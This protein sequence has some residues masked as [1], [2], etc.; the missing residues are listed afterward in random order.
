MCLILLH[1]VYSNSPVSQL[2][3]L[4][5]DTSFNSYN[6]RLLC[7]VLQQ[8]VHCVFFPLF[9]VETE[10]RATTNGSGKATKRPTWYCQSI[11]PQDGWVG[12][13][14]RKLGSRQKHPQQHRQQWGNRTE[15]VGTRFSM[16]GRSERGDRQWHRRTH[17][18]TAKQKTARRQHGWRTCLI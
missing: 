14:T 16:A 4:T 7:L 6:L 11:H 8:H 12:Q 5:V 9:L 2:T 17:H 10:T 13:R 18:D 15:S 1:V 3:K